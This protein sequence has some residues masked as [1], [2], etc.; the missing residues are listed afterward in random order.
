MTADPPRAALLELAGLPQ[1]LNN[2]DQLILLGQAGDAVYFACALDGSEAPQ[3]MEGATFEDLRAAAPALSADDAGLLGY[4]RAIV[5]WRQRHRYCGNCGAPTRALRGGHVVLCTNGA[6][7]LEVFPRIDP[8]IIVLI[9]DGERALLG[10]QASW[11]A[12]RY[13]TIAGFVEVGES[14][15]DAVVREVLEETGVP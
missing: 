7:A 1:G 6:C 12:G 15:E 9:S 4:A 11:P 5:T 10:R 2:A 14:L 8:A 3:L 13:S